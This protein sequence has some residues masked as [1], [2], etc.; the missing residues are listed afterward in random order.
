MFSSLLVDQ[1]DS[2]LLNS[3]ITLIVLS[4]GYLTI[5]LLFRGRTLTRKEKIKRRGRILYI[6]IVLYLILLARI[7]I[8]GFGNVLTMFSLVAAGFVVT[9]K[10]TIMNLVGWMIINWRGVFTEGDY[11]Q[12]QNYMGYVVSIG[13]MYFKV[14]ETKRLD[15]HHA[16]G[17]TLR[18]PNGLL[19][20]NP[21]L[22]ITPETSLMQYQ[23]TYALAFDGDV[24]GALTKT[25][26][27]I[28]EIIQNY[29]QS[30]PNYNPTALAAKNKIFAKMIDLTPSVTVKI[31]A[32]K[33]KFLTIL[34]EFYCYPADFDEIEKAFWAQMLTAGC[35]Q[36][37]G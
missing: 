32:E 5:V 10:E 6:A 14:Y 9:N 13:P 17:R 26:G 4:M 16:T 20:N 25:Q 18:I 23:L 21:I 12:I 36:K 15:Q 1:F 2:N 24:A 19:I 11:I 29:A 8:E 35:I 7:W 22:T 37:V 28:D 30:H 34:T 33:E 3:L 31:S 27:V